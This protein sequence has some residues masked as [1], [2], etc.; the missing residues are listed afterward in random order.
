MNKLVLQRDL[1]NLNEAQKDAKV[2]EN[3]ATL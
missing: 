2:E 1:E 3:E